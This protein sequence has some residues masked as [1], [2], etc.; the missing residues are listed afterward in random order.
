MRRCW[1]AT[2]VRVQL[3]T[4]DNGEPHLQFKLPWA[5]NATSM[6]DNYQQAKNVLLRLR[7]NWK[8]ILKFVPNIVRKSKPPLLKDI[9][10][11]FLIALCRKRMTHLNLGATFLASTQ[12]KQSFELCMM[13]PEKT[14]RRVTQWFACARPNL[15]AVTKINSYPFW[16]EK[17]W[18]RRRYS[19][20]FFK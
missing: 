12:H 11:R 2:R 4:L 18:H 10:S 9:S 3:V 16:G 13:Q 1:K 7:C 20:C 17:T 15:Y 5:H 14:Q 8:T 19:Q 6:K